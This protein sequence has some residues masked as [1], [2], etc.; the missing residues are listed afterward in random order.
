[1]IVDF[2]IRLYEATENLQLVPLIILARVS[3]KTDATTSSY[4]GSKFCTK[5][6]PHRAQ[7]MFPIEYYSLQ[8]R[9]SNRRSGCFHF[10]SRYR[11]SPSAWRAEFWLIACGQQVM[12]QNAARTLFPI[13]GR[14]K[15][16]RLSLSNSHFGICLI[17]LKARIFF[18]SLR[19][20]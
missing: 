2:P 19:E 13:S 14:V 8:S 16:G 3:S 18:W 7:K 5:Y 10:A 20:K 4:E 6:V 17:G 15:G 12:R 1:M 11:T 9:L